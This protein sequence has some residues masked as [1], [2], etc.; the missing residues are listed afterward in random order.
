[1]SVSPFLFWSVLAD[2]CLVQFKQ[3]VR[4]S[5]GTVVYP[6]MPILRPHAARYS[7]NV[8]CPSDESAS[9]R[10]TRDSSD[11]WLLGEQNFPKCEIR[12][13]GRQ[14]TAV[15]NLTLPALSSKLGKNENHSRVEWYFTHSPVGLHPQWGDRFEFWHA[16]L[17][18][19]RRPN[20]TFQIL[21]QSVP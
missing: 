9:A 12:Y 11:F 20:H 13:L 2:F 17:Y 16:V 15:P 14:W 6:H 8:A 3:Q 10:A 5:S 7:T 1:M 4:T 21:W 18:R 19:R